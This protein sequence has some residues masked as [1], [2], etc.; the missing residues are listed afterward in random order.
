M[1]GRIE[2]LITVDG[3]RAMWVGT[4]PGGASHAGAATGAKRAC[5]RIS[6]PRCRRPTRM[7]SASGGVSSCPRTS[8]RRRAGGMDQVGRREG[9]RPDQLQDQGDFT[10]RVFVR[11]YTAYQQQCEANGLST[12]PSCCCAPTRSVATT[13]DPAA[14]PQPL[15]ASAGRRVPGHQHAA[16][17]MAGACSPATRG[18]CSSSGDD[19]RAS[20]PPRAKIETSSS[21]RAT[22]PAPRSC[23]WSRNYR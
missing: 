5:R 18:S 20:M 6:I 10:Q 16:N 21:S 19:V 3:T 4:F 13:G 8:I 12:S 1:R 14:L 7:S 2:Q 22:F 23:G 17:T 9:I 11:V 15:A